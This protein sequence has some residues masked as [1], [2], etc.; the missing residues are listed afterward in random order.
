MNHHPLSE[1]LSH[2]SSCN[3]TALKVVMIV[4]TLGQFDVGHL[5]IPKSGQNS[6]RVERGSVGYLQICV[7]SFYTVCS[8]GNHSIKQML[9]EQ[10]SLIR[11]AFPQESITVL[12]SSLPN[13]KAILIWICS[14]KACHK[15]S[16]IVADNKTRS[17]AMG[18]DLKSGP[19]FLCWR[20][21]ISPTFCFNLICSGSEW[22]RWKA[23]WGIGLARQQCCSCC[24]H[25]FSY[26]LFL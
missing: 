20:F 13:V 12:L 4:G 26:V 10:V 2:S 25:L 18:A 8:L 24:T 9:R 3:K 15:T 17:M 19:A 16:P 7:C 6:W 11:V 14:M 5:F 23:T 1:E 21:L 22:N